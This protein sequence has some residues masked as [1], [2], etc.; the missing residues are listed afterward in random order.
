MAVAAATALLTSCSSS[1]NTSTDSAAASADILG[2]K[3]PAGGTPVVFGVLNLESGPV[4]FPEVLKGEQA[5][6]DYV[7]EYLGGIGGHPIKL[8]SCVTDGQPATST[9]CA[10]QIL[11]QKPVAILGAADTGAPAAMKV[12]ERANLAYLGGMTFTPAE[13]TGKNSVQFYSTSQGDNAALSTYAVKELGVSKGAVMYT[14]DSQGKSTGLGVI[15]PTMLNAGAK[16]VK[17]VAVPPAAADLSAQAA[18]VVQ[19]GADAVYV[20]LPNGCSNALRALQSVGNHAKLLGIGPCTEPKALESAG[21]AA[22]GL[23]TAQPFEPLDGGS[24]DAKLFN[25]VMDKYAKDTARATGTMAGFGSVMNIQAALGKTDPSKLTT[26]SIL[27]AFRTGTDHHNFL[28]H[29]YTCDGKQLGKSTAVC[30]A[31]QRIYQ[32]KNGKSA[33]VGDEWVTAGSNFT[34]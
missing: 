9:R 16:S 20:N 15:K 5:A 8:V 22:E 3:N 25:A 27:S 10:N 21:A 2:K 12:W 7:N 19:S 33:S 29:P 18:A 34:G 1:D 4:T 26:K 28:S 17:G 13:N 6:V 23:Y 14:D 32:V 11:D 30:N 24:K 31:Y